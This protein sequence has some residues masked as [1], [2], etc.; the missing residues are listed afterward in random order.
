VRLRCGFHRT[1]ALTS[2]SIGGLLAARVCADHFEEVVVIDPDNATLL[3][4]VDD[5]KTIHPGHVE[6]KPGVKRNVR[7]RVMQ[8]NAFHAAQ[9]M[10]L[11]GLRRLFPQV[12]EEIRA[13][14]A[15]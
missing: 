15:P 6:G 4:S 3:A 13:F 11:K 1:R 14:N 9:P 7:P 10:Y 2:A 8:Y 12:D 5:E